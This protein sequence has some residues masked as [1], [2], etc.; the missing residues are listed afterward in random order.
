MSV[1]SNIHDLFWG[2]L[3]IWTNWVDSRLTPTPPP[4]RLGQSR[5]LIYFPRCSYHLFVWFAQSVGTR[6][7]S[8]DEEKASFEIH[9]S[10]V[11]ILWK[12]TQFDS[13]GESQNLKFQFKIWCA[14]G[15][16]WTNMCKVFSISVSEAK[17]EK[18]VNQN[19]KHAMEPE[20]MKNKMGR[21]Y[22]QTL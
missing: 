16:F 20:G 22:R 3:G 15:K 17:I 6:S 11:I 1:P 10:S 21:K 18:T 8:P 7:W 4:P 14:S 2:A 5:L 12:L 13:K 9:I 19:I